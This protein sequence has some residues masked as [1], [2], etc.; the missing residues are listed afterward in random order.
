LAL[1]IIDIDH[2]RQLASALGPRRSEDALLAIDARLRGCVTSADTVMHVE[3]DIFGILLNLPESANV[4]IHRVCGKLLGTLN[5]PLR[6]GGHEI[7]M[8]GCVACVISPQHGEDALTLVMRAEVAMH[9]A[10]RTG[11]NAY[12]IFTEATALAE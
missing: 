5:Q 9:Q 4:S 10:K 3:K 6:V 7:Y 1:L 8:S 11:G 12:R 2:F